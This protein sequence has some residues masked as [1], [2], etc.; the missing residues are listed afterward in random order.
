MFLDKLKEKSDSSTTFNMTPMIDVVF[1]LIIFFM[2]VCQ[3]IIA[4]NFEVVVPDKIDNSLI[5]DSS[6]EKSSTVT[7]MLNDD[8]SV[9]YAVGSAKL[10]DNDQDIA[11]TLEDL[12][13]KNIE[14]LAKDGGKKIVN[15]R[16][17]DQMKF[18]DYKYV[19]IAVSKSNAQDMQLAVF[20][21]QAPK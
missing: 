4:E 16:I 1:L 10:P 11:T 14:G 17:S 18:R 3:F 21:D 7:A 20:K 6:T 8:G 19:L 13:N 5:K 12:I 9:L 2:L 15:L